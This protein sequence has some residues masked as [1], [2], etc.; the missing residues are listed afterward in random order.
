MTRMPGTVRS[1][2]AMLCAVGALNAVGAGWFA[3]A[4]VTFES[5]A[6]GLVG[7]VALLLAAIL[8]G[9]LATIS[10]VIA[11]K[12]AKGGDGV[13]TGGVVIGSLTAAVGAVGMT[14]DSGAWGAGI[15]AG[16]VMVALCTG[17][18]SRDWF[19]RPRP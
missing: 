5:G 16:G 18:D 3:V 11:S 8:A 2:R 1:V 9:A 17:R 15:V 19:D 14:A 13:R 6:L 12:F 4:G 10:L 7:V